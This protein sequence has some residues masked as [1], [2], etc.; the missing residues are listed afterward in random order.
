M[1]KLNQNS[2]KLFLNKELVSQLD[3]QNLSDVK[4]GSIPIFAATISIG[5]A[6]VALTTFEHD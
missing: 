1:K 2:S 6:L 3:N 5:A 4:G